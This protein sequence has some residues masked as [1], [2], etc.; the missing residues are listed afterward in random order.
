MEKEQQQQRKNHDIETQ[1]LI[2]VMEALIALVN[3]GKLRGSKMENFHLVPLIFYN[4]L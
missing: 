4:F 1:I 3:S 2:Y